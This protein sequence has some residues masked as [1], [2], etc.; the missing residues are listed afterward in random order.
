MEG[1]PCSDL[2][3]LLQRKGRLPEPDVRSIFTRLVLA[4]KRAHDCGTVLRNL[5]PETVQVRRKDPTAEY[6]V[7][8]ADLHCAACVPA[9]EEGGTLTGLHGTPEYAAPEVTIWYWHECSPPRLPEPP[10]AYGAKADVWALGICMHVMLCGCFPFKTSVSEEE[11]LRAINS[12]DFHFNDPGWRKLSED[13]LDLVRELLQRDPA[14]R[15][16]LEEVL[17]HPFCAAAMG[18]VMAREE[19]RPLGEVSEAALAQL[20]IDD[21]DDE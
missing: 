2:L 21:D 12:A 20:D 4:T 9:G 11:L 3:T 13:A 1:E 6:D 10:P 18:E 14:E 17:Q 16:C 7:C 8:V 5:K 19:A 15:P